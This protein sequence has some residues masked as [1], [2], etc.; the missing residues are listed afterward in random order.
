M[1]ILNIISEKLLT[2]KEN[3]IA[4]LVQEA[5]DKNISPKDILKDSLLAGMTKAGELFKEKKLSMFDVLAVAK[6]MEAGI[7]IIKP[8][9]KDEEI[10][11]KGLVLV[12]SVQGDFH[13]IGK[14]LCRLM[15][16]SSGF[17]VVDLGVDVP[18]EE[19]EEAILELRPDILMLSA[20]LSPTLEAM[21]Q[22][23]A[24]LKEKGLYD[25]VKVMVGGAPLTSEIAEEMGAHYSADAV[26]AVEVA[27][28][29]MKK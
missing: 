27:E 16:E 17:Q 8:F 6:N 3:E 2:G 7:N 28:N 22:T 21:K 26:S 5:V 14:N 15:L 29:L 20:M 4:A 18:P 11:R 19:I 23:V 10:R 12:G 13:D 9:L 25:R 1:E 24:Y